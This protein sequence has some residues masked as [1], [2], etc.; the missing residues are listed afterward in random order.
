PV[1]IVPHYSNNN[2]SILLGNANGTFQPEVLYPTA[3]S[4]PLFAAVADFNGDGHLDLVVANY[5]SD[6]V[7]ILPGNGDGT[8][9]S[10][11]TF[12]T[13]AGTSP[14]AVGG[15]DFNGDGLVDMFEAN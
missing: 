9:R 5:G 8:F 11:I 4:S 10:A 13:G 1:L 3:G 7:A 15:A 6:T 12:P 2:V 14:V